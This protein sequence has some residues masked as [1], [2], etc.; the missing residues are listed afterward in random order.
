[1]IATPPPLHSL[2]TFSP[3]A[4]FLSHF[5]TNIKVQSGKLF[6]QLEKER[7]YWYFLFI[8]T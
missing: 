5:G 8:Y 4:G 7:H 3:L 1:M 6:K 2:S